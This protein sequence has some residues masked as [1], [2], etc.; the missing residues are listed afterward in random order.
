[1]SSERRGRTELEA[2]CNAVVNRI[3][4]IPRNLLGGFSRAVNQ[5]IDLM[6]IGSR[7]NHNH[8]HHN[9]NFHSQPPLNFPFQDPSNFPPMIQEEWAFL[10]R[11]EQQF[12]N[13]HP[14]FYVCRFMDVLKI[15]QDEHKFLFVYIH[16]AE[17]PFVPSFCRDTLCSELVVQFLDANF[18]CWGALCNRGEGLHMCTALR[19]SSFPF[20]A[21]VAPAA[22]ADNLAVIQ[23]V[24]RNKLTDR[25]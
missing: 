2:T 19:V 5:G 16:E 4:K 18:V 21:V 8:D 15:A 3:V 12:G 9:Q 24:I 10:A 25:S 13:V 7:R 14:F 23:Q 1:M 17:H 20:C 22:A 6:N 11:F